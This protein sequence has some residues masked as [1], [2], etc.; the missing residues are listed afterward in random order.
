MNPEYK[1][2]SKTSRPFHIDSEGATTIYIYDVAPDV[3]NF[4]LELDSFEREGPFH[5]RKYS[6]EVYE[7]GTLR[8]AVFDAL[9]ICEDGIV[10]PGAL[11]HKY[12]LSLLGGCLI[13]AETM[14]Y[15]V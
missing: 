2:L 5:E 11:F 10:A 1:L 7:Y 8:R 3:Y 12:E 6:P 13:L 14:A 4:L 15:N 9:G